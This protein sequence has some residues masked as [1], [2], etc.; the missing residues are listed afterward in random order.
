MSYKKNTIIVILCLIPAAA[1]LIFVALGN[2]CLKE[3]EALAIF[4]QA[5]KLEENGNLKSARLKYKVIDGRAC[6]NYK[7]RG[8]A[9]NKAVI[10]Q[11][12]LRKL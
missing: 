6:T 12:A 5:V 1:I 7:L 3:S 8:E 9:F 10:V 2:D 11:E 4:E